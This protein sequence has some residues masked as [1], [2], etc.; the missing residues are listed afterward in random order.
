M[1]IREGQ[2]LVQF[3]DQFEIQELSGLKTP[4]SLGED[5]GSLIVE[6]ETNK[7]VGLLFAGNQSD[8]TFANPINKVLDAFDVIIA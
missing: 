7:A 3:E 1:L 5:S 6:Y 2:T 4:F 8:E